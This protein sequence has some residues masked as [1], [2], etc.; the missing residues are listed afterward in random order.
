MVALR[1]PATNACIVA[2]D[3][4]VAAS[5]AQIVDKARTSWLK[6]HEVLEL[7]QEYANAGLAVCH[8]PPVRPEG[9]SQMRAALCAVAERLSCSTAIAASRQHAGPSVD[10]SML[11]CLPN[12]RWPAVSLRPP[13]VPL[14]PARRPQLAQEA[15]WQDDTRDAREAQGCAL[16]S[17]TPLRWSEALKAQGL[18]LRVALAAAACRAA[19]PASLVRPLASPSLQLATLRL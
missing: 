7:L 8:E 3:A 18:A 11:R 10:H 15:G 16:R 4:T 9:A 2:M 5:I 1:S 19:T 12:R 17:L 13:C 14:L 6:N